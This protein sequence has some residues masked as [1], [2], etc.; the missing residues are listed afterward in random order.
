MLTHP[1]VWM[2]A[3]PI[4]L[5]DFFFQHQLITLPLKVLLEVH[6]PSEPRVTSCASDLTA[7]PQRGV[8]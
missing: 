5:K 4:S 8:G 2:S 7:R 1:S 6:Q 3:L